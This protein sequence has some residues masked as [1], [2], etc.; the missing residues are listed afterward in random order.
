MKMIQNFE[1]QGG[2]AFGQQNLPKLRAAMA[3]MGL[4]GFLIPH[5]DEYQNEYLPDCNERLMWATGFTGS[6]G[7][8][9]VMK[10]KAAMFV[11]GRYVIQVRSQVDETLFAHKR[12]EDRGVTSW[13]LAFTALRRLKP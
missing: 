3:S 7:A 9:I 1:V 11:D 12:V 4:D 5:E 6:A 13:L 2:P 10:D 8:A